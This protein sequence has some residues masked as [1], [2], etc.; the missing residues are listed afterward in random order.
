MRS[1]AMLYA[2]TQLALELHTL[3]GNFR[4]RHGDWEWGP[5]YIEKLKEWVFEEKLESTK[6][7]HLALDKMNPPYL[8]RR[9]HG[10]R[11]LMAC[12]LQ[13]IDLVEKAMEDRGERDAV[14]PLAYVQDAVN[15]GTAIIAGAP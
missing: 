3:E 14:G 5:L 8:L 2:E 6:T 10:H 7:R 11:R 1:E 9:L 13:E 12:L 4:N 15:R